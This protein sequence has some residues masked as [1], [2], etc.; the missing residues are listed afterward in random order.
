[1]DVEL[2]A[3]VRFDLEDA[4]QVIHFRRR[5]IPKKFECE[6]EVG[7]RYPADERIPNGVLQGLY[8]LLNVSKYLWGY[9]HRYESSYGNHIS[10]D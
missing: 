1:M 5:N 2:L 3:G 10:G 7:N 4:S 8:F 6:V 9:I